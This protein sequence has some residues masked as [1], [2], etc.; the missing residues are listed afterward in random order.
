MDRTNVYNHLAKLQDKNYSSSTEKQILE[1]VNSFE[2][3]RI[4]L[5][6]LIDQFIQANNSISQISFDNPTSWNFNTN[7]LLNFRIKDWIVTE[8]NNKIH[9]FVP[10]IPI[11]IYSKS[12]INEFYEENRF[13]KAATLK[14]LSSL[15]RKYSFKKA[16]VMFE[17]FTNISCDIDNRFF[18]P[19]ID[20]IIDSKLVKDDS[21]EYLSYGFNGVYSK[22][23]I[24]ISI[25]IK[26]FSEVENHLF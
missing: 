22:D 17:F 11:N 10:Y 23:K 14:K 2:T 25:T 21:Y 24:G 4:K 15:S 16:F 3:S 26:D 19:F 20:A 1:L 5:Y 18:K 9:M 7:D 12:L 8:S 13:I 6:S